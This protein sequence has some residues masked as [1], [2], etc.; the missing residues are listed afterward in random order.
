V[1]AAD[2]NPFPS[3]GLKR[4]ISALKKLGIRQEGGMDIKEVIANW[5]VTLM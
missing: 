5:T 1:E 3:W 2:D 4:A